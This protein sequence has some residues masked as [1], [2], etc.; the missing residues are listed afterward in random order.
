[1]WRWKILVFRQVLGPSCYQT[2]AGFPYHWYDYRH[3]RRY[4]QF[5]RLTVWQP[6]TS[7]TQ[8]ALSPLSSKILR[9]LLWCH[10]Q[11]DHFLHEPCR[12]KKYQWVI[13][14]PICFQLALFIHTVYLWVFHIIVP[15]KELTLVGKRT[16][17]PTAKVFSELDKQN[18]LYNVVLW[19]SFSMCV[20]CMHLRFQSNYLGLSQPT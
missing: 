18:L 6:C 4:G 8:H 3:N 14:F 1:M 5:F 16:N 13:G 19:L 9:L 17:Q 11:S 20:C 7:V 15:F 12:W 10:S 2:F